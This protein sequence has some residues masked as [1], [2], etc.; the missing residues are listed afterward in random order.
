MKTRI[1]DEVLTD[2]RAVGLHI[3]DVLNEG[4]YRKRGYGEYRL[5]VEQRGLEAGHLE[6]AVLVQGS[7]V[8][9]RLAEDVCAA[10]L[11]DKRYDVAHSDTDE[12]RNQ[13]EE[14]LARD[15]HG[16]HRADGYR[17]DQPVDPQRAAG[18]RLGRAGCGVGGG[19]D[20]VNRGRSQH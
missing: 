9:Q 12:D 2:Y 15:G 11:A 7:E 6:P 3:A 19:G 13:L 1:L 5:E 17:S 8:N 20:V 4:N 10:Q 14:A 16:E 18:Q